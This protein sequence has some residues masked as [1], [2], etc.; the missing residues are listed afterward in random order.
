MSFI[1]S[2]PFAVR[3]RQQYT[4]SSISSISSVGLYGFL[5]ILFAVIFPRLVE[6]AIYFSI[7][8][9]EALAEQS[10]SGQVR[11]G[12]PWLSN[13]TLLVPF[14]PESAT[15]DQRKFVSFGARLRNATFN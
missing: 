3:N 13:V 1:Q 8:G 4:Q 14:N 15:V 12:M 6:M 9:F 11:R 10:V 7:F 5:R 2:S